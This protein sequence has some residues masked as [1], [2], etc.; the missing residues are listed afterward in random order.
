MTTLLQRLQVLPQPDIDPTAVSLPWLRMTLDPKSGA[1]E[2]T[3]QY[4][5]M[6]LLLAIH[7]KKFTADAWTKAVGLACSMQ[8]VIAQGLMAEGLINIYGAAKLPCP[9]L[10]EQFDVLAK[11][12]KEYRTDAVNL[13]GQMMEMPPAD[14]KLS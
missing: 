6:L 2:E 4:L 14:K 12:L 3:M 5:P 9:A 11:R 8:T 1:D 10:R 13:V 7:D